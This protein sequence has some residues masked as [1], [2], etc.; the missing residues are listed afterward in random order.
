MRLDKM[1]SECTSESRSEI[2]K[3]IRQGRVSVNAVPVRSPDMK[4][5]ETRDTVTLDGRTIEYKPYLYIML[6]KPAG[7]VSATQDKAE[8]T[9]M[10][11][12]PEEYK[13]R[14][15]FVAGRLDKYTTGLMILTNDGQFAHEA[16]SPKSHV[17]KTYLVTLSCPVGEDDVKAF[18]DGI[19]I[20]GGY[21]TKSAELVITGER[22][23][24]VTISEGRYHQIKQ[25]FGARGNSVVELRRISFGGLRLPDDLKE[26]SARELSDEERASVFVK[27][28]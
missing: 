14:S 10:E 12:L 19:Y 2:K 18:K 3:L 21:L 22:S 16:L 28:D 23:A 9:V 15:L 27:I 17:K 4:I 11:L 13:G 25:M 6:N 8:R 5:D 20:E 1:L 24:R 26:G 7:Y